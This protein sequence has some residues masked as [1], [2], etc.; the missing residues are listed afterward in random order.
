MI[1]MKKIFSINIF[2]T[3]IVVIVVLNVNFNFI[4][5]FTLQNVDFSSPS[6]TNVEVVMRVISEYINTCLLLLLCL[7]FLLQEK[8]AIDFIYST[9]DMILCIA[10]STLCVIVS[11]AKQP[12]QSGVQRSHCSMEQNSMKYSILF[13]YIRNDARRAHNL[14]G[15]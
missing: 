6:S 5:N 9:R 1:I 4:F 7:T 12:E 13:R 14:H 2:T 11:G 3:A 15:N 10:F 8:W